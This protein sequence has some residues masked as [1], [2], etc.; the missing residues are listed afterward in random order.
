MTLFFVSFAM[1][2]DYI[3]YKKNN[4]ASNLK[5]DELIKSK[6]FFPNNGSTQNIFFYTYFKFSYKY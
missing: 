3:Y 2:Y 1:I 5:I 6:D 4:L